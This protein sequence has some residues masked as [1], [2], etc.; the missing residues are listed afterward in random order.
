MLPL[1]FSAVGGEL[2]CGGEV[3]LAGGEIWALGD[4]PEGFAAETVEAS[5]S[6]C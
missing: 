6:S 1:V 3:L 4:C 2:F 5:S